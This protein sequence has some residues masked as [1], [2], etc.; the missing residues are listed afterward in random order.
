VKIAF[1]TSDKIPKMMSK[2]P[3]VV[4]IAFSFIVNN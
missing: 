2:I 1:K 4:S 3:I